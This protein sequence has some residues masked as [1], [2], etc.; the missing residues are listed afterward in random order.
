[1]QLT[2]DESASEEHCIGRP[3]TDGPHL[4]REDFIAQQQDSRDADGRQQRVDGDCERRH[5]RKV[6]QIRVLVARQEE[7]PEEDQLHTRTHSGEHEQFDPT[8]P[9]YEERKDKG[10]YHHTDAGEDGA[11]VHVKVHLG[12][13]KDGGGVGHDGRV[14]SELQE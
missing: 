10:T 8:D 4:R 14:S 6:R 3:N 11:G 7:N 12:R 13:C 9:V 1:M 2:G 5:E